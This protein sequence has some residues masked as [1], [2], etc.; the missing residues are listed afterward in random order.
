M[1]TMFPQ[2]GLHWKLLERELWESRMA[3]APWRHGSTYM[4]WPDPGDNLHLVAKE[5][6]TILYN[7]RLLGRTGNP[8]ALKVETEVKQM[9]LEILGAPEGAATTLTAGGTESNYHAVKVARDWAREHLPEARA[10]EVVTPYTA[11]PSFDKAA[12]ILDMKIVRVPVG[13]DFRADV[14]AMAEAIGANT[15]MLVGSSPAFPHGRIDPIAEIAALAQ[16]RGLRCHVDACVGGFLVPFLRKLGRELENFDFAIPGVS[17]IS[18]DL[19]KFGLAPTGISSFSLRDDADLAHQRF[20]FDNWPYGSYATD[21]FAGSRNASAVA[22]AWAVMKHLGEDGYL[23]KARDIVRI[24]DLLQSGIEAIDG[25]KLVAPPE[26]GIVLYGADG[27][28][29]VAVADGLDA[30]GFKSRWC[31]EPPSIHLL[32]SPLQDEQIVVEYLDALAG[33]VAEVKAGTIKRKSQEAIY[34]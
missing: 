33:V 20:A 27:F 13:A 21:T 11:H 4:Y 5:A 29:I 31:K 26:A 28:D 23:E 17:S 10:P 18:A 22:G 6:A 16:E 30:R 9:V 19:H 7:H 2:K 32:V 25:L 8:S 14:G 24:T 12:Q 3:D 15:V 1:N 34:A